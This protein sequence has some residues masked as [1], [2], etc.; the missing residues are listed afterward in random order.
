MR[1]ATILL[2]CGL[3]LTAACANPVVAPP[4][5]VSDAQKSC[6]LLEQDIMETEQLKKQA[7]ADDRFQWRYIFVV[8]ALTS[9]YRIN[10]AEKAAL[11]RLE[12]LNQIAAAKGCLGTQD[13]IAEPDTSATPRPVQ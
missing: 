5:N 6:A 12:Q 2:S 7:R 3:F 11:E 4:V 13:T 10:K 1:K 8:N 9:A